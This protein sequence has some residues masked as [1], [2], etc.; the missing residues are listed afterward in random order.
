[1]DLRRPAGEPGRI[2]ENGA[3]VRV[4]RRHVGTLIGCG[5]I[6]SAA[7]VMLGL[8]V[9]HGMAVNAWELSPAGAKAWA[10]FDRQEECIYHAI[11]SEVPEGAT[12]YIDD[13]VV[14]DAQR[15][16]E[17][18]TSWAVPQPSPATAR[19][20]LSLVPGRACSGRSLEVRHR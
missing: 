20:T 1:V 15:L 19:W 18:S 5:L 16:A 3:S 12:V 6:V 2:A 4:G 8:S 13:A 14:Y 9:R 11:R 10:K 7:A 17:L